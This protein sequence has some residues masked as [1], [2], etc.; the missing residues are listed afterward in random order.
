MKDRDLVR[1]YWPV[2]LRPT[3]DALFALDD[4]MGD[5]VAKA[6]DP[7]LAAIKLAWWRERLEELD[8]GQAPAEPR[9]E[10]ALSVLIPQG[11]SGQELAGLEE[12][13]A[14]LLHE[15][16]QATFMR[17]VAA[18]GPRLFALLARLLRIE[19][20]EHLEEAAQSFT[21]SDLGRR[22]IINLE[23]LK[24]GRSKTRSRRAIRPLTMLEVLARR[25]M[26]TGG[27]PFE[28][29]ATPA[30]AFALLRHRWTG[31]IP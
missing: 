30:R 14:L 8:H 2:E 9:L 31:R 24:L 26:R 17:G 3:F 6:T 21:A 13:W 11:I 29:E 20:D 23:P 22:T 5:V 19:M 15:D 16:D 27:P 1:L 28:P 10:A 25:D 4:A 18:R 12:P 7:T